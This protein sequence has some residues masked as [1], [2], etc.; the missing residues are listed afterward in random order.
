MNSLSDNECGSERIRVDGKFF[1]SGPRKWYVKGFCYG[2]CA[3][4]SR[5]ECLPEPAQ[6]A[7]DFRKMRELGANSIRLYTLPT[8]ATLDEAFDHGLKVVLDVPWEKHRCF[9]EDWT[10]CE[11]ARRQVVAAAHL[12]AEHP[13]V[14]A[15]SVVNEIPNDI[16]R[17]H[18]HERLERFVEDLSDSVKQI[19][20][21][22]LTTFANYPTTEFFQPAGFDFYFFNV[23]LHDLEQLGA[24]FD[25]LQHIAGDR[26]LVLGEFGVDSHR[27][28]AGLQAALV[29]GHVQTVF[30]H[31]LA[32]SFAFSFTDDWF[33]GGAQVGDWGFGVTT[34]DRD[35]KPAAKALQRTWQNAPFAEQGKVPHVSVVVCAYNAARTLRECLDSLMRVD[36]PEYE[37]IL[38]DDGSADITPQIAAEFPQVKYVR[39]QNHGLSFARNVGTSTQAAKSW[40]TRMLTAWSTKIGFAA[41]FRRCGTNKYR[42]SAARILRLRRMAGALVALRPVRATQVTSCSTTGLR[43]TFPAAIWPFGGMS[44]SS[45]EVLI[46]SSGPREMMSISAGACSIMAGR[47]VTHRVRLF[48]I[49]DVRR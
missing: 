17:F 47:L 28:G 36:Y 49:T 33:T 46:L 22:C 6:I 44:F 9:L 38:I 29:A 48:G 3:L 18:G 41:S 7:S 24:Y 43:N 34:Y 42:L 27:Q 30:Q 26:P 2:P 31:G 35:E 40:H 21:A 10:A 23:Y 45:L 19:A 39:Q 25:R 12:A 8:S 5:G 15:V 4:N 1:R 37:V 20:P 16:V 13:S 32:G 14:M 11:T